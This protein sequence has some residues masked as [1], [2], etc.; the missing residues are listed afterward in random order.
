MAP[1]GSNLAEADGRVGERLVRYYEARARGGAGLIIVGVGAVAHPAGVCIPNQV[2]I[3]NDTFVPGLRELTRSVHAHGAKVA[4]QLQHGGKVARQDMEVG[5]PMWVPSL[6]ELAAGDLLNDLTPDE[7]HGVIGHLGKPG[8]GVH[9]HEMTRH[10]IE[11]VVRMFAGAAERAR[12]AGFDGVE[13]HAAHGYLIAAFLSAAANHRSDEY[14]G[15]LPRRARLLIEVIRAVRRSVGVDFPVWCRL[16]AREFHI[17]NGITV[18]DAERTAE[19]AEAA[20]ADAVHVSAYADPRFGFAFTE[21]PLVHQPCGYVDLAARIKRRLRIP[22][23]VVGRIEPH[24]ANALIERG[25][26]DFVAMARKLLADPDLPN[27]LAQG[28]LAD[29]RPC[30]YGY[31]CVGNIYLNRS[32][33]C[34]VNPMTGR[35]TE[36]ILAPARR[37]RILVAGGGPAGME[38]ARLAA[39]RGHQVTLCEKSDRLGGLAATAGLVYEPNAALVHYLTAHVGAP[40]IEVRLC[41]EV[42]PALVR[43]TQP[44]VLLIAV[45]GRPATLAVPGVERPNVVDVRDLTPETI[46]PG[47]RVVIIGGGA[48]AL[49]TAEYLSAHGAVVTLL[50]E[51]TT[52]GADMALPRR[53]RALH[54]LRGRGV[55]L[56]NEVH[57]EGITDEAVLYT[58]CGATL[59]VKAE[60]VVLALPP[61]PDPR[62]GEALAGGG[63]DVHLL[64]DC[65]GAG[66]I[67]TALLDAVRAVMAL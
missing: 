21:A 67:E 22:L 65:R 30:T 12:R 63:I 64:G 9:F 24:E 47:A 15:T 4:I 50:A 60:F 26:A 29:V 58:R 42:T 13:I 45:G 51:A 61:V 27:K 36:I 59:S 53:W 10:D 17:E 35:E 62:L 49:Q 55:D 11:N 34:A 57:I 39:Q 18:E 54:T 25:K 20:G 23:I 48:P 41:Q 2:A 19:L 37:R 16:D 43:Q 33:T 44:D 31:R 32:V 38:A 3:S 5:R 14:G 52:L 46:V 56:L 6:P 7:V 8:A 28:R 66:N 1:M 40:G